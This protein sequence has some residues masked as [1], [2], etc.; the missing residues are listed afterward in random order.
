MLDVDVDPEI[1]TC[2][3]HTKLQI[4]SGEECFCSPHILTS[5]S[6]DHCS[7]SKFML[8]KLDADSASSRAEWEEEEEA[9][10]GWAQSF[11]LLYF[12]EV[13]VN[14]F[15]GSLWPLSPR[16]L[17]LSVDTGSTHRWPAASLHRVCFKCTV[18][19]CVLGKRLLFTFKVQLPFPHYRSICTPFY[20]LY[21]CL[22][23]CVCVRVCVISI[24]LT[25]V[26]N[27]TLSLTF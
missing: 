8:V 4:S 2:S 18:C 13:D 22:Y 20:S 7:L 27:E 24:V 14:W 9:L 10:R 25:L 6:E 19:V 26:F 12:L 21:V 3:E 1:L 17:L 5:Q 16:L 15:D 23:L 11:L